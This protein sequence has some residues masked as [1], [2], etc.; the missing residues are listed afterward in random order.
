M[1][2]SLKVFFKSLEYHSY[3]DLISWMQTFDQ[4]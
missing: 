3:E 1:D 4:D 2:L